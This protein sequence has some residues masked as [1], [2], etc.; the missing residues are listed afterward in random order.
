MSEHESTPGTPGHPPNGHF[1][2]GDVPETVVAA[3]EIPST[4][5]PESPDVALDLAAEANQPDTGAAATDT[6]AAATGMLEAAQSDTGEGETI[7]PEAIDAD[8]NT[9]DIRDLDPTPSWSDQPDVSEAADLAAASEHDD[10]LG[11]LARAMH[12]AAESQHA[13]LNDDIA[14]RRVEQVE[15]IAARVAAEAQDLKA[16]S[17]AD[18]GAIDAWAK[19]ETEKIKRE[20]LLRIDAR[21]V[22]LANH[23]ERQETIR[24]RV[25]SMVEGAIEDHR[26]EIDAFFGRMEHEADPA[27]IARVAS[28][29]PPFPSLAAIAEEAR[30]GAAAEFAR[31]DAL[32]G[33]GDSAMD[34][35]FDDGAPDMA[36][37]PAASAEP[38]ALAELE[39]RGQRQRRPTAGDRQPG[40]LDPARTWRP[41]PIGRPP[42]S[43]LAWRPIL[44]RT[45]PAPTCAILSSRWALGP[46]CSAESRPC[47]RRLRASIRNPIRTTHRTD[48]RRRPVGRP[49]HTREGWSGPSDSSLTAAASRRP[50]P[51]PCR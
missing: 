11:E 34:D 44:A 16:G 19:A 39:I 46:R 15:A 38:A 28:T 13:R 25:V 27:S 3:S 45:I 17:E 10:F 9:P 12:A 41:A 14:R 48:R 51:R 2:P 8:P 35:A 18:V 42:R 20:R 32:T 49:G 31:L 40:A 21:R 6:G 5:N 30:R 50:C 7:Q 1:A 26:V 47:G 22:Q 43:R 23:L 29:L 24:S 4:P 37:A 36:A 33:L